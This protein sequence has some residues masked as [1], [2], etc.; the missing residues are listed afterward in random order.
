MEQRFGRTHV[1]T[2]DEPTPHGAA[3][4]FTTH[5]MFCLLFYDLFIYQLYLPPTYLPT[6]GLSRH[7]RR[8]AD[9]ARGAMTCT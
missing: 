6:G 5:S 7:T 8:R 3:H 9:L 1:P 2:N 4:Y